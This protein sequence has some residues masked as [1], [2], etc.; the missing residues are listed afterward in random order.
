MAVSGFEA[1]RALVLALA[2]VLKTSKKQPPD[3]NQVIQGV[4][5]SLQQDQAETGPT[6]G[7]IA[8]LDAQ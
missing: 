6:A 5:L 3:Q 8:R 7:R 4:S 2:C 1:C